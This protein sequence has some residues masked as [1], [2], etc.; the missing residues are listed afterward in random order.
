M[1]NKIGL[2][3]YKGFVGS[4]IAFELKKNIPFKAISRENY[5]KILK[6]NLII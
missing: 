4:A 5:K 1:K 6:L 2:L 3:G